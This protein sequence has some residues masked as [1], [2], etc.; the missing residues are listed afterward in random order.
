MDNLFFLVCK[1]FPA[2]PLV[3]VLGADGQPLTY[4]SRDDA[5]A[6]RARIIAGLSRNVPGGG[7]SYFVVQTRG[8]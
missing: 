5:E 6:E 3:P 7:P 1:A 2:C 4:A 8:K